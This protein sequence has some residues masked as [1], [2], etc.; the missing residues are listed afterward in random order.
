MKTS[1]L[2]RGS[3]V[4]KGEGEGSQSTYC[5]HNLCE[6]PLH[7][8]VPKCFPRRESSWDFGC[9]LKSLKT[10]PMEQNSCIPNCSCQPSG[11]SD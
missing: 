2:I 8:Y 7:I 4:S 5:L 9:Y 11:T 3:P 10:M 1:S 6:I